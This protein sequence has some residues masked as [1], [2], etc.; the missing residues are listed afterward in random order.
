MLLDTSS[1]RV[2]ITGPSDRNVCRSVLGGNS[3]E[4]WQSRLRV[5]TSLERG[6][7]G[8]GGNAYLWEA[9]GQ[10]EAYKPFLNGELFP[11]Q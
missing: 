8:S 10:R 7:E 11:L 6:V 5:C 4:K 1:L 2:L 3:P 9:E